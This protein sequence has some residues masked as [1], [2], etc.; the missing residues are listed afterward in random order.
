MLYVTRFGGRGG[1]FPCIWLTLPLAQAEVN[2]VFIPV[3][4]GPD[5]EGFVEFFGLEPFL[6]VW[7]REPEEDM[8]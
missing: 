4:I 3:F 1:D 2:I 5:E 7:R 8:V 6:A